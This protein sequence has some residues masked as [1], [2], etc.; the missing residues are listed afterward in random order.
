MI[1]HA[2]EIATISY[3]NFKEGRIQIVEN[4]KAILRLHIEQALQEAAFGANYTT[5]IDWGVIL[6]NFRFRI[7]EDA[8]Y[9][10]A[11]ELRELGYGVIAVTYKHESRWVNA[12][13]KYLITYKELFLAIKNGDASVSNPA[14]PRGTT[15]AQNGTEPD[16]V[17]LAMGTPIPPATL[18]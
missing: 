14:L 2:N 11:T 15:L 12:E 9:A 16:P 13:G 3:N 7:K 10:I 6:T 17:G 18:A 5:I 8:A 1:P 4:A